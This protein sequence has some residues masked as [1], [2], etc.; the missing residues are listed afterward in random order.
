MN[1]FPER[2][3]F[4]WENKQKKME[5]EQNFEN[6]QNILIKKIAKKRTKLVI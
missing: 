5:N 1:D 4:Q 6:K 2:K 3:I